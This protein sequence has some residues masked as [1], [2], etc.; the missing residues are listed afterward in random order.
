M[1]S[2]PFAE[3]CQRLPEIGAGR[4]PHLI[5]MGVTEWFC[6]TFSGDLGLTRFPV[7]VSA[8]FLTGT[9]WGGA[10]PGVL[11]LVVAPGVSRASRRILLDRRNTEPDKLPCEHHCT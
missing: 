6:K 10:T 8:L 11:P 3:S 1:E 9:N 7:C 2:D 5:E 4:T